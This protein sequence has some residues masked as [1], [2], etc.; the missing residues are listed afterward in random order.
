MMKK[1]LLC[2]VV[3]ALAGCVSGGIGINGGS[4]GIGA[5]FGLGTG[6]SF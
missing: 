3:F 2:A 6:L 1:I 5:T 4:N